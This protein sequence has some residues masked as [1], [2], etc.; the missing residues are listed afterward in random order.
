M[1]HTKL[2]LHFFL[3]KG[4]TTLRKS[5]FEIP[6]IFVIFHKRQ[7]RLACKIIYSSTHFFTKLL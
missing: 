4:R 2:S 1:V 3:C 5:G 7:D 6:A